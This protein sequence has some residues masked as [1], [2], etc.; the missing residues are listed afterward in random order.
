MKLPST[1]GKVMKNIYSLL[2]LKMLITVLYFIQQVFSISDKE[3]LR[4][5]VKGKGPNPSVQHT[6]SNHC[7]QD[8]V[9]CRFSNQN[10]KFHQH[11]ENTPI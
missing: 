8:I 4:L 7:N 9:A 2:K 6:Q 3:V 1:R 5:H 10:I 11:H